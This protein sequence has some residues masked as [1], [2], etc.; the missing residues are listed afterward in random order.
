MALTLLPPVPVLDPGWQLFLREPQDVSHE[1]SCLGGGSFRHDLFPSHLSSS[2]EAAGAGSPSISM[3]VL[4]LSSSPSLSVDPSFWDCTVLFV[5]L[6]R[7]RAN[8]SSQI[9]SRFS[10]TLPVEDDVIGTFFL[11]QCTLSLL[12]VRPKAHR[13]Q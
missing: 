6:R 5:L 12:C 10:R 9:S 3:L 13:S 2:Q 11:L 1:F 4:Y 8:S 7:I